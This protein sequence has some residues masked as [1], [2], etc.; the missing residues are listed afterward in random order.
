MSK[1][2]TQKREIKY[3]WLELSFGLLLFYILFAQLYF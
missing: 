3:K 1:S 2:K